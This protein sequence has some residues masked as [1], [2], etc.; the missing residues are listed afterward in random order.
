MNYLVVGPPASIEG[1]R[2]PVRSWIA[3]RDDS[4]RDHLTR[5]IQDSSKIPGI[6]T[7]KAGGEPL[8]DRGQQHEHEGGS[9][10]YPPERYRPVDLV[11][12]FVDLV[13]LPIAAV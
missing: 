2:T 11:A 4:D 1:A 5:Q 6:C 13:G 12:L 7:Q 8:V 3:H 10:V 9:C